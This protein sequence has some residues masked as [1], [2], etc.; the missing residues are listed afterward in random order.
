MTDLHRAAGSSPSGA[1]ADACNRLSTCGAG[2]DGCSVCSSGRF[3]AEFSAAFV[4]CV[5]DPAN[6][7]DNKLD[8]TCLAVAGKGLSIRPSDTEYLSDCTK[9]RTSCTPAPYADDYCSSVLFS[10]GT[11]VQMKACLTKDCTEVKACLSTLV[12]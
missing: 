7:C 2:G 4:K 12:K 1:C 11:V 5:S 6:P 3:R 8:D 9:K 10:D